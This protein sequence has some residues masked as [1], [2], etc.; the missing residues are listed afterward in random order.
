MD[1]LSVLE[2]IQ[3]PTFQAGFFAGEGLIFYHDEHSKWTESTEKETTE[4]AFTGAIDETSC[5]S[6]GYS[7][8]YNDSQVTENN[9]EA[10]GPSAKLIMKT[11]WHKDD[12]D[13]VGITEV[14]PEMY[15][16]PGS[17]PDVHYDSLSSHGIG[18]QTH[19]TL[20]TTCPLTST[21]EISTSQHSLSSQ[22]KLTYTETD[23][24]YVEG[25]G[26]HSLIHVNGYKY[27][28][29][30]IRKAATIWTCSGKTK[31]KCTKRVSH[32]LSSSN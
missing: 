8:E 6:T 4:A 12:S 32:I 17:K 16:P 29:C 2:A 22:T 10:F 18:S 31:F 23:Y 21:Q 14:T 7:G 13:I 1:V 30:N 26:G 28:K 20:H 27:Y 3:S 9:R 5:N 25:N 24:T 19:Q 11:H 15:C